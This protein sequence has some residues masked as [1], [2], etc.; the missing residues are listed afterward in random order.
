M[1]NEQL[2]QNFYKAFQ[3]KDIAGMKACYHPEITFN[4]EAFKNLKGKQASAMWDML[5]QGGKDMRITFRDVKANDSS[6]SAV[7]EAFYTLSLTGRKVHNIISAKF[8]FKDGKIINHQDKFDFWRW[9]RQAFGLTGWLLGWTP[10][11]RNKVQKTVGERL[12]KF[13]TNHPEYQ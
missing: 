7:W 6:G 10:I 8:E 1:T 12:Q 5:I 11:L 9:S 4:D 2:I 13:I 3:N